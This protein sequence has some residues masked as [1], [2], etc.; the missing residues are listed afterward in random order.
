M[1]DAHAAK[2]SL[3]QAH[4]E[5]LKL[6]LHDNL[7][8]LPNRLLFADRLEQRIQECQHSQRSFS[9]CFSISTAKIISDAPATMGRGSAAGRGRRADQRAA[10]RSDTASR[11]G[12]RVRA[13]PGAGDL[14]QTTAFAERLLAAWRSPT[15]GNITACTSPASIGIAVYPQDGTSLHELTLQRRRRHVLRQERGRNDYYFFDSAMNANAHQQFLPTGAATRPGAGELALHYQPKCA[16]RGGQG[17][18]R[19]GAAALAAPGAWCHLPGPL[20]APGGEPPI[21]PIGN[22]VLDEACR[23]MS[24]WRA[25]GHPTGAWRSTS[26]IQLASPGLL[27][28]VQAAL[29]RHR[30]EARLDPGDH[31]IT[32]MENAEESLTI[33]NRLAELGLGIS[34]DD[35]GTGYSSLLPPSA[36]P[37]TSSR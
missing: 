34:I 20:P 30:L 5:L 14:G 22:W 13:G 12:G 36:S 7:T 8:R 6:A 26:T 1:L 21:I 23:Q 27:E 16:A 29:S 32:A 11:F 9:R 18:R 35:F 2:L 24:R 37:P 17:G 25:A 31:Q 3:H 4:D 10:R 28:E 33:L 15:S 19:R